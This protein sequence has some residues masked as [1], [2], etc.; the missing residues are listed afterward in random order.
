MSSEPNNVG[1]VDDVNVLYFAK[2]TEH[3]FPPVKAN[4][5][6]AGYD[7]KRQVCTCVHH[8]CFVTY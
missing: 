8:C 6:A 5:S 1:H 3:A 7:L 4:E 2:L